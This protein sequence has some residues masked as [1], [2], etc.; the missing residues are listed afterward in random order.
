MKGERP[1]IDPCETA[2]FILPRVEEALYCYRKNNDIL[3]S[4]FT[5]INNR[6]QSAHSYPKPYIKSLS[7]LIK[8]S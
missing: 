8:L 2:C 5:L 6:I 3:P 1:R 7:C 4:K